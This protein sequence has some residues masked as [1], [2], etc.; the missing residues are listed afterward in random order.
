VLS[1]VAPREDR[2]VTRSEIGGHVAQKDVILP[3]ASSMPWRRRDEDSTPEYLWTVAP[4]SSASKRSR[5]AKTPSK[6]GT[7]K[8]GSLDAQQGT[9]RS[10]T[11]TAK[12]KPQQQSARTSRAPARAPVA[13]TG[14]LGFTFEDYVAARFLLDVLMRRAPFGTARGVIKRVHR[15]ARELN[16]GVDDLVCELERP[17]A[18]IALAQIGLSLKQH[19]QV[20][21]KGFPPAFVEVAWRHALGVDGAPKVGEGENAIGLGERQGCCRMKF[22]KLRP[23]PRGA[24]AA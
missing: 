24:A 10:K 5:K 21:E 7:A 13:L 8:K 20:T 18:D 9:T 12:N 15:Q 6:K 14:G 3:F 11:P 2:G 22:K 1:A 23:S 19:R 17:G 4:H 16:W